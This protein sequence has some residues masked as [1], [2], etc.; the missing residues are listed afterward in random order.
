MSDGRF[1]TVRMNLDDWK[2]AQKGDRWV[3]TCDELQLEVLADTKE[4]LIYD[5]YSLLDEIVRRARLK[6]LIP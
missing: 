6:G 1:A 4:R 2:I 3:G 5:I